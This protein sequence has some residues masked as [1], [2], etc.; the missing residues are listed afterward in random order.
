M[1][2]IPI[3]TPVPG[4]SPAVNGHAAAP[5]PFEAIGRQPRYPIQRPAQPLSYELANH[6]KAYLESQQYVSGFAFLDALL[7]SGTSIS[8]PA[9]PYIALLAPAP[10]LALASTL[11][12]YPETTTRATSHED[13]KG[14][15]AATQ[16]L[17]SVHTTISPLNDTVRS[18]YTFAYERPRRR[19][20]RAG[21]NSPVE[22]EDD[23]D[24]LYTPAANAQAL[25]VRARDFWHVVGW[26]FNC[27]VTHKKRWERW[28][29]WLQLMLDY[30]EAEWV[31]RV[32]LR[33]E[34]HVD[35]EKVLMESL[36]WHYISS[37]DPGNRSNRRRM[38]KAILAMGS[39]QAMIQYPEVWKDETAE[40]KREEVDAELKNALAGQLVDYGHDEDA[41][42]VDAPAPSRRA[43]ASPTKKSMPLEED[44]EDDITIE[45]AAAAINRL[46]GIDA[47]RLRQRIIAL[48]A[49]VAQ[50]LPSRFT[51]LSDFFDGLTEEMVR[52]PTILFEVLLSTS[53]LLPAQQMA[54]NANLLLP[55]ASGQMPDYIRYDPQQSHL[56][57]TLLPMRATTH[58][59][60]ANAKISLILE[61]MFMLMMRQLKATVALRRTMETGVVA[62]SSVHG[63]GRGK[64]GNAQ[65]EEQAERILKES[66]DRLFGLLEV[67]ELSQGMEPQPMAEKSF[68]SIMTSSM[69]SAQSMSS[70]GGDIP[71]DD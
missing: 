55:L 28:K 6:S 29:L 10:Q 8:T 19:G 45:D 56:E 20:G 50:S 53:S 27:S 62:R 59:F 31:P 64:R 9:K 39:A 24:R 68:D 37:D 44:D 36:I 32:K 38:V 35:A 15:D 65:E 2:S 42:M 18:A 48:L 3:P 40:P 58:S 71:E 21:S 30:L 23:A 41:E 46:G 16:Y 54:L 5:S 4:A 14:A 61:Q 57:E 49:Q 52:L 43:R 33:R 67:L 17:R 47:I 66:H 12:V 1:P 26:A 34:E 69:S 60:A 25:W 51:T 7:S 22:D 11:I 63:T 70:P 13:P